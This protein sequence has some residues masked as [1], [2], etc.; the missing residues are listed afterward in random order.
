MSNLL[1]QKFN[2]EADFEHFLQHSIDVYANEMLGDQEFKNYASAYA[3]SE[4]EIMKGHSHYQFR[5]NEYIYNIIY[6]RRRVGYIS[7][8]FSFF[9]YEG[10]KILR[11]FLVYLYTHPEWRRKH[12]ARDAILKYEKYAVK[13]SPMVLYE[14]SVSQRNLGAIG[15]YKGLGYKITRPHNGFGDKFSRF[16]MAKVSHR[17]R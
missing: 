13:I 7:Y 4:R 1:F 9:S 11:A 14:L 8:T 15:L 6:N 16:F 5:D 3:A 17:Q 12:I 2:S 10:K